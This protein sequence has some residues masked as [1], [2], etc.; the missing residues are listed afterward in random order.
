MAQL[1]FQPDEEEIL[2]RIIDKAQAFRDFLHAFING[3]QIVRTSEEMPTILFYLRK[4]EGA[5]VLL[6]D[7]TNSFRQEVHKWQPIAPSPPPILEQSLSTRKPRPTKQQK[8]MKEMG[9]EKVEDL[10]P[11]FRKQ[12]SVKRKSAGATPGR[13]PPPPLQPAQGQS[14]S[15]STPLGSARRPSANGSAF[16]TGAPFGTSYG[17][18]SAS[19][20]FQSPPQ[21]ASPALF[22]PTTTLAPSNGM[23][24][25]IMSSGYPSLGPE[26]NT[27]FAGAY[28]V[29]E[30]DDIRTGI[31]GA[32]SNPA[33]GVGDFSSPH[34]NVDDMFME[35]TNEEPDRD[36]NV[37]VSGNIDES[38]GKTANEDAT[39]PQISSPSRFTTDA[40]PLLAIDKG[41]SSPAADPPTDPLLQG[42]LSD[43]LP[44]D[45]T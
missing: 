6:A 2:E 39:L 23:G 40:E 35:M 31:M 21:P 17:T 42:T 13:V 34:A 32:D 25:P 24:E 1:P 22:S 27:L 43:L 26:N 19:S 20:G 38:L 33:N 30:D 5:E 45:E 10:P 44:M 3:N 9:V 36:E 37:H 41:N 4:I 8:M 29:G 28:N 12:P 7:E 18:T 16:D 14:G 15:V 11:Q